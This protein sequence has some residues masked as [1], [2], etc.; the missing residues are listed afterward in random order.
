VQCGETFQ[1]ISPDRFEEE[2]PMQD[3]LHRATLDLLD[4]VQ[5]WQQE[6]NNPRERVPDEIINQGSLKTRSAGMALSK[7]EDFLNQQNDS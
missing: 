5:L 6:C 3:E 7:I 2:L 4:A 1:T